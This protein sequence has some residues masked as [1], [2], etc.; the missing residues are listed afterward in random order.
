MAIATINPA[1][2]EQVREFDALT[3]EQVARPRRPQ[4]PAH[5]LRPARTVAREDT[6]HQTVDLL[7]AYLNRDDLL[8][9]LDELRQTLR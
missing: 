3:D 6:A 4:L 5:H 9:D 2:G 7:P 8:H 1:T